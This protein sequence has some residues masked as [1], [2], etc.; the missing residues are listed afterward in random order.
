MNKSRAGL[1]SISRPTFSATAAQP[2][3]D[4]SAHESKSR[5]SVTPPLDALQKEVREAQTRLQLFKN[6]AG[7]MNSGLPVRKIIEHIFAET[8]KIFPSL[9]ISYWSA[10]SAEKAIV[11]HSVGGAA[12]PPN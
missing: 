7:G 3:Q 12:I 6:L 9:R 4:C 1:M 8:H 11:A 2:S 10:S 5:L